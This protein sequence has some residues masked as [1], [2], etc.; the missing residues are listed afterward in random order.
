[1]STVRAIHHWLDEYGESHTH[2]T[3]ELIHWI[4]LP[5]IFFCGRFPHEHSFACLADGR[6]SSLGEGGHRA[7]VAR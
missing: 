2:P 1:M 6:W 4:C 3:N 5:T 7:H